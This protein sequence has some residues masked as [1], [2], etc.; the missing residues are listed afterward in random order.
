MPVVLFSIFISNM[1]FAQLNVGN[2]SEKKQLATLG[3]SSPVIYKIS[4]RGV[5]NVTIKSGESSSPSGL[6]FEIVFLN[7]TSSSLSGSPPNATS[8][9]TEGVTVPSVIEQVIP[10]KS[11]DM[12]I[13]SIDGKELARKINEIPR[14]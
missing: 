12:K 6:N 3:L 13:I 11:F 5:Y 8:T 7:A 14:R 2:Q 10:V 1:V 9:Q 4:E